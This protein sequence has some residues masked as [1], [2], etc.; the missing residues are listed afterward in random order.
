[1]DDPD[2][3]KAVEIVGYCQADLALLHPKLYQVEKL[4]VAL[5]K[6]WKDEQKKTLE[7]EPTP[8]PEEPLTEPLD[9]A[10]NPAAPTPEPPALISWG[11]NCKYLNK[12]P[13]S[14]EPHV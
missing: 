12:P 5:E 3:R 4:K 2:Y 13:D 10:W 8:T 11:G 1:M 7:R 9:S 6:V 14:H